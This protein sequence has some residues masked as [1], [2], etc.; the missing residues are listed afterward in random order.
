MSRESGMF[1]VIFCRSPIKSPRMALSLQVIITV[2]TGKLQVG[3][4]I[5]YIFF[6]EK[7]DIYIIFIL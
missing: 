6:I 4:K 1:V 3:G 5:Q 2:Q 7:F